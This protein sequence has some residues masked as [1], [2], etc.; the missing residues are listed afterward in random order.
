[1]DNLKFSKGNESNNSDF[2]LKLHQFVAKMPYPICFVNNKDELEYINERFTN[3]FG[4]TLTD[5]PTLSEWWKIAYPDP[6]YREWV[7]NNWSNAVQLAAETN[8]DIE[9]DIYDVSCKDGSIRHVKIGGITI[10]DTF[11]AT[12]HDFTNE[13]KAKR[14]LQENNE[15]LNH[16]NNKLDN[17]FENADLILY[18]ID[19]DGIF[20]LSKGKGLAKLGLQPNQVV[21]LSVYD[22]YKDYPSVIENIQKALGGETINNIVLDVSNSLFETTLTPVFNSKNQVDHITGVSIDISEIENYKKELKRSE[23]KLKKIVNNVSSGIIVLDLKSSKVEEVNNTACELFGY[24]YEEFISF[25][26]N[27]Y[28]NPE[29]KE[30]TNNFRKEL[31]LLGQFAGENIEVRKDGTHFYSFITGRII[32]IEEVQYL[33]VTIT[34]ITSGKEAQLERNRLFESTLTMLCTASM[35]GYFLNVNPAFEKVLGWNERE[36]MAKPFFDF[37]HPD[38]VEKTNDIV[39]NELSK[40]TPVINFSNR[41]RCKDGSYKDINWLSVPYEGKLYAS[42]VDMTELKEKERALKESEAKFKSFFEHSVIGKSI[43]GVDGSMMVNQAFADMVGYSVKEMLESKWKEITHPDDVQESIDYVQKIKEGKLKTARWQK[44]YIHKD[45]HIIWADVSTTLQH[46]D[47]GN[48][49][50]FITTIADITSSKNHKEQLIA[51]EKRYKSFIDLTEQVGWVTNSKG[52]IEEDVASFRKFTG[53][54]FEE[55]KGMGWTKAIHPDDIENTVAV[56]N[57]AVTSKSRYDVEYRL[58]RYDGEYRNMIA[59]GVPVLNAEGRVKEWIGVCIDITDRKKQE[60]QLISL[61]QRFNLAAKSAG[62]GIWDLDLVNNILIWDDFMYQLY[63]IKKDDFT[64]AYEAWLNGVHP[65]D[66]AQGDKDVQLAL[67][68]EKEFDSE[69]RVILPDETI[70][71]IHGNAYVVRDQTNKPIRMVGINYDI[72]HRKNMEAEMQRLI[73]II[74]SSPDFIGTSDM[75]GNLMYH[76]SAAKQMVGIPVENTMEGLKIENLC[77]E[78]YL[79][80][81]FNEGLPTAISEGVWKADIGLKHQI[82]GHEIPVSIALMVHRN[83]DGVPEYTSTVM[84]D[85]SDLKNAMEN[86]EKTNNELE[87]FNSMAIGREKRMIEL[88]GKINNLSAKLGLPEPYDIRFAISDNQNEVEES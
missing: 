53:K 33:V 81:V 44:R 37:I 29:A 60:E 65:D 40:G 28:T 64:S 56:W 20:T 83:A 7:V 50:Y 69:F 75:K 59:R 11:I 30:I 14:Q 67:S 32:D 88:K 41:Y 38:D 82:D 21:G 68:G 54:T 17:I 85:I 26:Y 51:S 4:Y 31:D 73:N 8:S 49:Q 84:R 72:T 43:T 19:N 86:L 48:P 87:I 13:I 58:I 27:D 15:Q 34:D 5:V 76:N 23:N 66:R 80:Q 46:D 55:I 22:V 71:F 36:L 45:G 24:T 35:D 74:D 61:N 16:L 52:E 25:S 79:E 3:L 78:K 6:K 2:E 77:A 39:A 18:S 62:L 12:F 57:N 42:A 63:G 47:E 10:D 70:R 9:P 1:M